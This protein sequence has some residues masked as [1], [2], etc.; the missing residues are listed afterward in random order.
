MTQ[1][2]EEVQSR[3]HSDRSYRVLDLLTG[4]P[5]GSVCVCV[6]R[7]GGGVVNWKLTAVSVC[8]P[9]TFKTC[10]RHSLLKTKI[11]SSVIITW[12]RPA[13]MLWLVRILFHSGL[14]QLQ[15]I[16]RTHWKERGS[17]SRLSLR[18]ESILH[19]QL[20]YHSM[21]GMD[22]LCIQGAWSNKNR[23]VESHLDKDKRKKMCSAEEKQSKTWP[24]WSSAK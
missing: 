3:R 14:Q 16:W 15:K 13:S 4:F 10:C 6:G 1:T 5:A 21:P 8:A 20:S 7:G 11:Q 18:K 12:T 24:W 23:L 17:L 2:P 22:C 9:F 19:H